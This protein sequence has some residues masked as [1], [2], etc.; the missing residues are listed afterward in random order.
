MEASV[1]KHCP[2]LMI[3]DMTY[4]LEPTMLMIERIRK[5]YNARELPLVAIS[6]NNLSLDVLTR[7]DAVGTRWLPL[8]NDSVHV[9]ISVIEEL[10]TLSTE[11][12]ST[13]SQ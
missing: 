4:R 3:V 13:P 5:H 11:L 1:L 9:L 2:H 6:S 8:T 12:P 10:I 7:L